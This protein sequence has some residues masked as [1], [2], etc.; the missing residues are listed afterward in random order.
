[1]SARTHSDPDVNRVL[2][3]L[4]VAHL[5]KAEIE[6]CIDAHCAG[7]CIF[8]LEADGRHQRP[9]G[10]RNAA[11]YLVRFLSLGPHP[12]SEQFTAVWLLNIAQM[13]LGGWPEAVD[14]QYR[15]DASLFAPAPG[16]NRFTDIAP[17]L[18]VDAFDLAGGAIVDDFDND[19]LLDIVTS[20]SDPCLPLHYYRNNGDG[21]FTD[22]AEASGLT[23]QLGGLNINHADYDND[24]RLD[25]LVMRGAWLGDEGR[26]RL[27][28]LR[29]EPDGAFADVTEIA[30][31]G[32]WTR[33]TQSADW[34]LPAPKA[35]RAAAAT[36]LLTQAFL[37][38]DESQ[39]TLKQR[40]EV[41][42]PIWSF[43][44]P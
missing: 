26:Q 17:K 34:E 29:N 37:S 25:I 7:S 11:K 39:K 15:L 4:A 22:R 31:L 44:P 23:V 14:A 28:L 19:G 43:L 32:D 3:R 35:A 13:A 38:P 8:P 5:R 1:M 30:G 16:L 6:N 41:S 18:G 9:E 20:T 10:A 42:Q 27:S 40:G 24:G 12:A 36:T 33:P 2:L 21:T